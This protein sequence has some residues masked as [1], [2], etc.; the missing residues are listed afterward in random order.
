MNPTSKTLNEDQQNAFLSQYFK[1]KTG[2]YLCPKLHERTRFQKLDH[3]YGTSINKYG[4][5]VAYKHV[6]IRKLNK[7]A[8]TNLKSSKWFCTYAYLM[9]DTNTKYTFTTKYIGAGTLVR[10]HTHRRL[11]KG[12]KQ[13]AMTEAQRHTNFIKA[14]LV[15]STNR[16]VCMAVESYLINRLG[17]APKK[18]LL[19]NWATPRIG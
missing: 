5:K 4:K 19:F 8:N 2:N 15:I 17:T 16:D 13:S 18:G 7:L 6:G 3:T 11:W 9:Q 14:P 10:Y 1:V 12:I